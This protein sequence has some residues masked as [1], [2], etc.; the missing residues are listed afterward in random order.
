MSGF[1]CSLWKQ[2]QAVSLS[3]PGLAKFFH[4]G[5]TLRRDAVSASICRVQQILR[6]FESQQQLTFYASSL[7]FV[8]EGLPSFSSSSPFSSL[9][10]IH[11]FSPTEGKTAAVSEVRDGSRDA[12][13]R[14]IQE[15]QEE[16]MEECNNNSSNQRSAPWDYSLGRIYKHHLKGDLHR[17]PKTNVHGPSGDAVDVTV[18]SVS[19]DN[20]LVS[21]NEGKACKR[22]GESQSPP[23]VNRNISQV[24]R[25]PGREGEEARLRR[26]GGEPTQ[27][28]RAQPEVEVRMIDFAHVFQSDSPDHGYIYGLKH[29]LSVLE[30]IHHVLDL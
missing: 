16:N 30:Q 5:V 29:L 2:I 17:C 13:G 21:C 19:A 28:Q 18:T 7:L 15:K 10:N 26:R 23:N 20:N 12:E 1:I 8:Y 22:K 9:V 6:W 24:E 4:N 14:I 11:S 27:G 25:K 3:S